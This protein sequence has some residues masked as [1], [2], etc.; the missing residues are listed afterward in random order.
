V[1]ERYVAI[2]LGGT[3]VRI[4]LSDGNL[5]LTGIVKERADHHEGPAGIVAQVRR[6]I[7]QGLE[8][9]G[10]RQASMQR[11]VVASPG[12]LDTRTGIVHGAPNMPGWE[13][14]VP[15]RQ[16]FEDALG[17]PVQPVNDAN[18]AAVGEYRRGAGKGVKNM[19]YLTVSTGIGG[20]V[21]VEG[22]L[23]E[24]SRGMA[25]EIG[26]MTIDM[27]GPQCKCGN[28]GCLEVLASGTNIARRFREALANGDT[29]GVPAWLDGA[30]ATAAD[31]SRGA[32]EGDPLAIRVWAACMRALGFGVVNCIHIFNPDIVVLGGGVTNA[33]EMVF[34]PVR[35][36]VDAYTMPLPRLGVTVVRAQLR[37]DA[38]LYGAASLAV[39]GM[40]SI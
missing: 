29:S 8:E 2:D 39:E 31:V 13:G 37:D 24:G 15:L 34:D 28:I 19:V 5:N 12:P 36:V 21:I 14:E 26:H 9:T 35:A 18:V 20:G 16:M 10:T 11:A 4:A 27:E 23:L 3:Q 32:M 17:I 7:V 38:G 22:R 6:M 25:G 40:E 33:G 30:E 1:D